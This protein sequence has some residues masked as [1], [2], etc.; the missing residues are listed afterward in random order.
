MRLEAVLRELRLAWEQ[1]LWLFIAAVLIVVLWLIK[2]PLLL[3]SIK[4]FFS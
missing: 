3:L 2:E 1:S 4:S